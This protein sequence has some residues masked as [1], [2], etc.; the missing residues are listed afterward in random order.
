VTPR[1]R[2]D[3][4]DA[5]NHPLSEL[6]AKATS[7][8][9]TRLDECPLEPPRSSKYKS[10][11]SHPLLTTTLAC[12]AIGVALP[13]IPPLAHLFGFKPLPLT[14]LAILALMI[15]TYL[16]LA[17]IG[18]GLFFKPHGGRPLARAISA[19]ERRITRRASR[20]ASWRHPTRPPTPPP[21]DSRGSLPAQTS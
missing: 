8:D 18:V 21:A 1:R 2:L 9:G 10:R 17:Q 13:Y 11:P 7:G 20:W 6:P 5:P 14:F 19:A 16:A 3:A 4:S 15:A 12:A